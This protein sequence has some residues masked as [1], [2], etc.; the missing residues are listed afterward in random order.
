MKDLKYE[1][2]KIQKYFTRS[3]LSIEQKKLLF[4]FRTRMSDFGENYRAGREKVICPLCE[5]H[6]DNQKLSFI[7]PEIKNKVVICGKMSDIYRD[8][9]KLETVEAIQKITQ[10]RNLE[11]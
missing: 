4:K 6:V 2:I 5:S 10:I 1:S 8:D 7:C 3:D 9:I 11:D